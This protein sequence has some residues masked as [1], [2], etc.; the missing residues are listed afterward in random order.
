MGREILVDGYNVIKN[1]EPF[2]SAQK[3][4]LSH[5]RTILIQQVH[6]K[7]RHTPYHVTIVF[8]GDGANEI[9]MHERRLQIIFSRRGETADQVIVRKANE[10]SAQG[11]EVETVS[12]DLEVRHGVGQGGGDARWTGQLTYHLN[13]PSH[14]VEQKIRHRQKVSRDYGLNP[15]YK[16]EDDDFYDSSH[17][18]KKSPRRRK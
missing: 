3:H 14:D 4:G 5:A 10:L 11:Q 6:S 16:R 12:D 7:Y 17:K 1:N 13:A 18:G 8:D 15:A 2:R 9:V